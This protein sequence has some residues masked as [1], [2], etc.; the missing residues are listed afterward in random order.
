MR[1]TTFIY[2]LKDPTNNEV[3]Y[4]GKSNDPK[5]RYS[6]HINKH[7]D[8]NIHK[9]NWINKLKE[10][11]LKPILEIIEEVSIEKWKDYEKMYI[12]KYIDEGCR[13]LN[14]TEGGDGCTFANK[15]SFKKGDNARKVVMLNK[16]GSYIRTF[17]KVIDI[18]FFFG[19]KSATSVL[20]KNRKTYKGFLL[21][22]ESEYL[23]MSADDIS[24]HV[25]W[26][27]NHKK[28]I[29]GGSFKKNHIP[30]HKIKTI[31]QYS[32]NGF[33]IKKWISASEAGRKLNINNLAITNC[34]NGVS[35]SS[36]GFFWS[37]K[38]NK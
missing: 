34:A 16:S 38:K 31:Y 22:Y 18:E 20:L 8:T 1:T 5:E 24:N 21:L 7:K 37:Y 30:K 10:K 12:K 29:N 23:T 28:F 19:S 6:S 35:K 9:V 3:R 32:K 26:A 13:L 2:A 36:G 15:T 25:K 33:F 17:D 27:T 11:N 4:I 14:Y